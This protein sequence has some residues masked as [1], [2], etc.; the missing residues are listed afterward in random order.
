[1]RAHSWATNP[2]PWHLQRDASSHDVSYR[3]LSRDRVEL[4]TLTGLR[5][6]QVVEALRFAPSRVTWTT[7]T[8][9]RDDGRRRTTTTA[10]PAAAALQ[11]LRTDRIRTT[12]VPSPAASPQEAP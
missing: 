6:R 8:E 4:V 7:T 9:R 12:F 10:W 1:M 5:A 11:A 3:H 2:T